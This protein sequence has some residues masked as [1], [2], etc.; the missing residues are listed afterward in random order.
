MSTGL[1]KTIYT[2]ELPTGQWAWRYRSGLYSSMGVSRSR[3]AAVGKLLS[4]REEGRRIGSTMKK[5][6]GGKK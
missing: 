4:E 3:E 6:L 5:W 1:R 2:T